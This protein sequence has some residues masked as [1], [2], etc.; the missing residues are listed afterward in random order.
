MA[1]NEKQNIDFKVKTKD[2]HHIE[3]LLDGK[4][5]TQSQLARFIKMYIKKCQHSSLSSTCDVDALIHI[6]EEITLELKEAFLKSIQIQLRGL[7]GDE[8][9]EISIEI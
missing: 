7:D 2:H 4:A 6:K 3:G 5:K 9:E 8:K 1:Y